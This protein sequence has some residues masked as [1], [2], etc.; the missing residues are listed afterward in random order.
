VLGAVAGDDVARNRQQL[1][2]W[3]QDAEHAARLQRDL[4]AFHALPRERQEQIRDLDRRLHD[5]DDKTRWHLWQVMERYA[6]W[7]ESVPEED[8]RR[9][10]EAAPAE[11]LQLVRA[12]RDRQFLERLPPKER[13]E[14]LRLPVVQMP[15]RLAQLR[16]QEKQRQD[17]LRRL[18]RQP[19][20]ILPGWVPGDLKQLSPEAQAYVRE[21]LLPH[22]TPEEAQRLHATEGKP[23]AFRAELLALADRHPVL[24][25]LPSGP[26]IRYADLPVRAKIIM[27]RGR[28]ERGGKWVTLVARQGH[29]PEFALA[30][31]DAVPPSLRPGLP[32]LGA[33][34]LSEFPKGVPAAIESLF[35]KATPEEARHLRDAEGH[36]PDYPLRL[37]ELARKKNVTLPGMMLTLKK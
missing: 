18:A 20:L 15:Q 28:L 21:H 10:A 25:P 31:I 4:Q 5:T 1:T 7:L 34:R 2:Q 33:S 16:Q 17:E 24:P 6:A 36:W 11:R 32:P 22:L 37:R 26:V 23:A 30:F 35:D 13:E 8:R 12:I 3:R 29:W 9:L 27:P 14:V 19:L